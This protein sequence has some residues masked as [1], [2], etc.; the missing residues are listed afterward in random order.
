MK[1]RS[2]MKRYIYVA[3]MALILLM[4]G[5]AQWN[6]ARTEAHF[7]TPEGLKADYVSSKNQENF[8]VAATVGDDGKIRSID[9][10][11]TAITPEAAI[12]ASMEVQLMLL[13]QIKDLLAKSA[14]MGAG[15]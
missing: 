2:K 3:F 6:L 1:K 9:I 4:T 14:A 15:S 7:E 10:K 8:N 11:T 13:Q 5:C 12:A